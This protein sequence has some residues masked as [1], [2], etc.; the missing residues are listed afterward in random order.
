ME[1]YWTPVLYPS[2]LKMAVSPL[3][4]TAPGLG[5]VAALLSDQLA[6]VFQPAVGPSHQFVAAQASPPPSSVT[7]VITTIHIIRIR[8]AVFIFVLPQFK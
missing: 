1:M 3:P 7:A 4:G 8:F 5:V 2:M 6:V